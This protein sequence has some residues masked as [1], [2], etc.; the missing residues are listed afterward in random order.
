M[1]NTYYFKIITQPVG[2]D[3]KFGNQGKVIEVEHDGVELYCD[4]TLW[5]LLSLLKKHDNFFKNV[6]V[7]NLCMGF[8]L[9]YDTFKHHYKDTDRTVTIYQAIF[10]YPN[11]IEEVGTPEFTNVRNKVEG[12]TYLNNWI[13]KSKT[14]KSGVIKFGKLQ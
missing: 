7:S 2:N 3:K 12:Q 4:T 1:R 9:P 5:E 13:K 11:G 14:D 8:E 6:T 10:H